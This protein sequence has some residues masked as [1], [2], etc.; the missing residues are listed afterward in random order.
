MDTTRFKCPHCEVLVEAP[1]G[2][3]GLAG[4]C[5]QCE[6]LLIVPKVETSPPIPAHCSRVSADSGKT[7]ED[8]AADAICSTGK[9]AWKAVKFVAPKAG[10][11]AVKVTGRAAKAAS[12]T[13]IGKEVVEVG[14]ELVKPPKHPVWSACKLCA[15][16]VAKAL[17]G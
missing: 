5:P 8:H 12:N 3:G 16:L 4:N 1:S 10:K 7:F 15:Y 13:K 6:E 2:D 9:A 17:G 11:I 14:K